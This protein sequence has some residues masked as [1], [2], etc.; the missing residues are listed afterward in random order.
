MVNSFST[1]LTPYAEE[2][3]KVSRGG[4]DIRGTSKVHGSVGT[5]C[6]S[7]E[8]SARSVLTMEKE[9]LEVS[10]AKR[11]TSAISRIAYN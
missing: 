4:L 1:L 6:I 11:T 8:G 10:S 3:A 9:P 5:V 2:S 7:Q